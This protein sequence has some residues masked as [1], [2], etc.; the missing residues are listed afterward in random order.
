M[1]KS[2]GT[3]RPGRWDR[4]I[5]LFV[6]FILILFVVV[7]LVL[8]LFMEAVETAADTFVISQNEIDMR[9]R[10]AGGTGAPSRPEYHREFAIRLCHEIDN[11]PFKQFAYQFHQIY[12]THSR[13]AAAK[14]FNPLVDEA[15]LRQRGGELDDAA[16]EMAAALRELLQ[17]DNCE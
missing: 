2:D 10:R 6:V 1:L 14:A 15:L 7:F 16:V 11:L 12:Q 3:S 9:D 13:H 17:G 8:C 5:F 4:I